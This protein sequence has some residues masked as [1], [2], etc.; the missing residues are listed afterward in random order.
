VRFQRFLAE[1]R[2]VAVLAEEDLIFVRLI[3]V[4]LFVVLT[5]EFI[6]T[7][8]TFKSFSFARLWVPAVRVVS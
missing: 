7:K 4:L 2:F 6:R 3:D 5:H 8:R 1:G